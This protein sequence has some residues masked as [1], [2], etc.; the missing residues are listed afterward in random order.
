MSKY[1][2]TFDNESC[3]GCGLC[4]N[5]CPR[6]IL[7]LD[8][9]RINKQGYQLISITDI[10][11]CIGCQYCAIICPDSVIEVFKNE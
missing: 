1:Y 2:L 6:K 8:E 7:Y 5:F 3:K 4:V 9:A 10:E 11:A